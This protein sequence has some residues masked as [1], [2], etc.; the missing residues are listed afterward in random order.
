MSNTWLNRNH[1]SH[2]TVK[3]CIKEPAITKGLWA[4]DNTQ[5]TAS[6]PHLLEM[7]WGVVVV[8]FLFSNLFQSYFTWGKHFSPVTFAL[9][10]IMAG[11][12]GRLCCWPQVMTSHYLQPLQYD[13][14]GPPSKCGIHPPYLRQ[15]WPCHLLWPIAYDE[16][17]SES[18]LSP[19]LKRLCMLSFF[20]LCLYLENK[21][22]LLENERPCGAENNHLSQRYL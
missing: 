11:V 19:G 10:L 13:F 2:T 20:E 4:P 9:Q 22:R 21:L 17:Y 1:L 15:G 14:A 16:G 8:F 6:L 18:L 7:V 5:L 3:Q 12:L